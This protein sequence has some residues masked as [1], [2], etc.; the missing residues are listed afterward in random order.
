MQ[1]LNKMEPTKLIRVKVLL[2]KGGLKWTENEWVCEPKKLVFVLKR[3]EG[4]ELMSTKRIN[5]S[6][7]FRTD[8][9]FI[10]NQNHIDFSMF[11][12]PE[13]VEETKAILLNKVTK[14]ALDYQ[15][16]I[17]AMVGYLNLL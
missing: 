1:I 16:S 10:L 12:L 9:T 2:H 11:S 5:K 3:Y 6:E 17:N 14:V 7:I 8:S 13:N 4:E 15:E